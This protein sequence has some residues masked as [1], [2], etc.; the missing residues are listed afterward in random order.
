MKKALFICAALICSA[1]VPTLLFVGNTGHVKTQNVLSAA[2]GP[3]K[4][5]ARYKGNSARIEVLT[6]QRRLTFLCPVNTRAFPCND[7]KSAFSLVSSGPGTVR[8]YKYDLA[9]PDAGQ[10]VIDSLQI[11]AALYK[12]SEQ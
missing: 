6:Q 7:P 12:F 2:T 4:F 1:T 8:Y 10:G 3:L 9:T 11:G 5:I